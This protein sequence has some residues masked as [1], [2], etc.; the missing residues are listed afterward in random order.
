MD[1]LS[2]IP[3]VKFVASK[4]FTSERWASFFVDFLTELMSADMD[5]GRLPLPSIEISEWIR[6]LQKL[7]LGKD[8]AS[9]RGLLGVYRI[10][11]AFKRIQDPWFAER[12]MKQVNQALPAESLSAIQANLERSQ[13]GEVNRLC[14][15]A[16]RKAG[17]DGDIDVVGLIAIIRATQTAYRCVAR[18]RISPIELIENARN[19]DRKAVLTLIKLDKLFLLD[20]C[21]QDVLQKALLSGDQS[22]NDQ[23]ARAQLFKPRFTR[24]DGCEVYMVILVALRLK[25]PPLAQLRMV[26]DPDGTAFPKTYDFEKCFERRKRTVRLPGFDSPPDESITD[27]AFA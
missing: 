3:G 13:F 26:L 21:T 20:S 14:K 12:L 19:G 24:R 7:E 2:T 15:E 10:A 27:S 6:R 5:M 25:L 11:Q 23:V 22:F 18:Y 8:I 9:W 4:V 17:G 16:L 1:T